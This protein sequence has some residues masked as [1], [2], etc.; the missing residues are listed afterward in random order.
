LANR[1]NLGFGTSQQGVLDDAKI[2]GSVNCL[3]KLDCEPVGLN[4][5]VM[6]LLKGWIRIM[7]DTKFQECWDN[8][9]AITPLS[10]TAYLKTYWMGDIKLWSA[11]FHQNH[12]I[13]QA[14][15]TNMLV[16]AYVVYYLGTRSPSLTFFDRWHHL[17]KGK[18]MQGKHNQR[19]DHLLHILVDQA[20][21]YFIHRH[22]QQE[23]GF[24]GPDLEVKK[25][26]DIKSRL[27]SITLLQ[28]PR[29][30]P[31]EGNQIFFVQ[32]QSTVGVCYQVD[33]DT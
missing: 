9:Q 3:E 32:S 33:L 17:L 21:P 13:F 30:S 10:F 28:I 31:E 12:N 26:L 1:R 25:R 15:D 4:W 24:E 7:D 6:E 2:G 5:V 22:C 27:Q 16:E 8:I 18:L 19:L 14:C 11:V 20:M 23:F 29:A